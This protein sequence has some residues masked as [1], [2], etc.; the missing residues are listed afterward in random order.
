MILRENAKRLPGNWLG[1]AL[2]VVVATV[3]AAQV[4]PA[5][6]PAKGETRMG[7][8]ST[9]PSVLA[10]VAPQGE[11]LCE[12]YELRVGGQKVQVYAARVSASTLS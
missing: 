12:D 10:A 7:A 6:Q 3:C 11:K 4:C 1:H 5:G 2:A 8:S 9:N